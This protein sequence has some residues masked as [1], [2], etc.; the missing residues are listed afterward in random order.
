[1]QPRDGV[2]YQRMN[3]KDAR[4]REV[5]SL[6]VRSLGIPQAA[7]IDFG[8]EVIWNYVGLAFMKI[9]W[10]RPCIFFDLRA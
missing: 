7:G 4:I 9:D 6:Y 5:E 2:G 1:M 8:M 3:Q 10:Y